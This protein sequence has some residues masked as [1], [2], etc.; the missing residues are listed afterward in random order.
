MR[1]LRREAIFWAQLWRAAPVAATVSL[2]LVLVGAAA[3]LVV[4]AGSA[5]LVQSLVHHDGRTWT[6][7]ALTVGALVVAPLASILT[8]ATAAASQAGA[9]ARQQDLIA[10]AALAPHGIEHLETP[11]SAATLRGAVDHVRDSMQLTAVADLWVWLG[12]RVRGL[13]ALLV[14]GHWSW[15]AA[16]GV[17]AA[18]LANSR[19]MARYLEAVQADLLQQAAVEGRRASYLWGLLLG[20]AAGK[21]VRLFGLTD[22]LLGGYSRTWAQ[23][24]VGVQARRRTAV[25]PVYLTSL[26]LT[27]V[28]FAALLWLAS[29]AWHGRVQVAT[30]VA[31]AQGVAALGAF[32]NLGDTA[33][34]VARA[35]AAML[36]AYDLGAD[37]PVPR[38]PSPAGPATSARSAGRATS[39]QPAMP[40]GTGRCEV[41]FEGVSFTYP[42]RREPVFVD[43]S[44]RIPAGQSVALVGVNGVGKSTLV[45][46]LCGLYRPGRGIVRVDGSDPGADD[47]ARRRVAVI[48]QDFVRYQ[49]PLRDN[50][51]LPLLA[52]QADGAPV[53]GGPVDG[54]RADGGRVDTAVVRALRDA[55]GDDVLR[56]VGGD[57]S[58]PLDPGY[59]GGVDLSGGQWQHVALARA[60]AAIDAGAGVLVLDEPTAALDVRAEA[61]LFSRFLQVTR[62]VTSILVSHRLSSVRHADRIVVLGPRGVVQDGSHEQLLADG[63]PYAQMFRLQASRFVA[64]GGEQG[65][66]DG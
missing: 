4:M 60:L 41:E 21:E 64:A 5:L 9:T 7:F 38:R 25:R 34:Q 13:A 10:R 43:L 36:A 15:L 48:F 29:D 46:L 22:W 3:S 56:R 55:G 35:K 52:L 20:R 19:S 42:S 40:A 45:K 61:E 47:A 2:V 30:M 58:T 31:A 28:T 51:G 54:A 49:L 65:A 37:L 63:G 18:Q 27:A 62:G 6:W 33:V 26:L 50:V 66:T 23:A 24:Q 39:A 53:E 8:E 16:A 1:R 11:E 12:V 57:W 14:V 59:P 44:L 32:G 17:A